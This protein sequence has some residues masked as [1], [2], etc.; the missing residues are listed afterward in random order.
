MLNDAWRSLSSAAVE[1]RAYL[2]R[3]L[4]WVGGIV[5]AFAALGFLVAP[6]LVRPALERELSA[7]LDRKVSI[8]RL[9]V[10]PFALSATLHAVSVADRGPGPP[11]LA[12]DELYLNAELASLFR[13]APVIS[14]LKL[15]RPALN[16]V[17]NADKT[18]NFSDLLDRAL[19][20]PSGPPP[21][22]SVSNIEVV[23][24][25]ITIDDRPEHRQHEITD[26]KIGIP[27][28]SSLPTQT[29][30]KVEPRFSALVNGRPVGVTG[31]TRP[32]KETHE[33]VL[34]WDLASLALPTYVDY[35][36]VA[37]PFKVDS[38]QLGAKLDFTFVGRGRDPPHERRVCE[39]FPDQSHGCVVVL[40]G[41]FWPQQRLQYD[42]APSN[43]RDSVQRRVDQQRFWQ[44]SVTVQQEHRLRQVITSIL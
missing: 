34:H 38:G 37:L 12:F 2:L 10:N 42:A 43:A 30:I 19:A 1:G 27:F 11:M 18:Y 32:F 4:A 13:W 39:Q 31:E 40:H 24:G 22:F 26:L 15:S 29:E 3:I 23:D 25:H 14:E 36:P 21:R 35:L 6:A 41:Q 33:T 7:A 28:L 5:V 8:A 20:G 17:R 16:V 44:T 9:D